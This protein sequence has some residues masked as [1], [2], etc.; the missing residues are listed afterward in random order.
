MVLIELVGHRPKLEVHR[1]P[2]VVV[3]AVV[4]LVA[5]VVDSIHHSLQFVRNPISVVII[6][7]YRFL[8]YRIL[9]VILLLSLLLLLLLCWLLILL[10]S[11]W[12]VWLLLL[13]M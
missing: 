4:V 13:T 2:A 11:I 6:S 9:L 12:T 7:I 10:L 3:A 5:V 8:S 1:N